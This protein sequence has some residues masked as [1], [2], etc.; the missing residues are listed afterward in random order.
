MI[1]SKYVVTKFENCNLCEGKGVVLDQSA[2][3]HRMTTQERAR[4][5]EN[6]V[7]ISNQGIDCPRCEGREYI[8][9]QVELRE[10]IEDT[11]A[12]DITTMRLDGHAKQ[13]KT[14][15]DKWMGTVAIAEQELGKIKE[16][17]NELREKYDHLSYLVTHPTPWYK[18]LLRRK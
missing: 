6:G 18:K 7:A 15:E 14:I 5:Q 10:A 4:L 8:T 11:H 1:A 9:T 12:L 17:Y 2:T 13:I 16:Q 3:F